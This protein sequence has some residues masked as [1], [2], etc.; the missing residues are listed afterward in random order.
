MLASLDREL[1]PNANDPALRQRL[2]DLR[3]DLAA[4]LQQAQNVQ[5]AEWFLRTAEQER[6]DISKEISNDGP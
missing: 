3:T 6:A 5:R 4:Q 2:A 1:I